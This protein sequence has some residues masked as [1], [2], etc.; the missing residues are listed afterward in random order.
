[1]LRFSRGF[2]HDAHPMAM[3]S[4]VVGSLAAFYHDSTDITRPGTARSSRIRLIAKLPTIAAAGYQHSIGRPFIY[5]RNDLEYSDE[6]PAHDVRG[7]ERAVRASTR[8]RQGARPA[9]H[10]ARRPR[11]ERQRPRPC[12]WPAA[13]APTCTPA[14]AAGVAG[15]VGP[16]ARRRQ[17]GGARH[18]RGDRRRGRRR[19]SSST[20]GQ[21]QEVRLPPDGLRPPRLQELR[22]ARDDHPRDVPRGA[23]RS[24]ATTTRCSTSRCGW[25]K[26]RSRTSTSSSASSTRTSISTRASSTR[27]SASRARCSR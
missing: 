17:R 14:I 19:R 18:A 10:P 3:L 5:P 26:P 27:R 11:A 9:V 4:A 8:R 6:L 22:P 13:R 12:A 23:R 15:A 21:G 20:E 25:R 24:S 16:R 1:M 2:R 7:A